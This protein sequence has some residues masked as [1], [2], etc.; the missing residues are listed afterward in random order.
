[1]KDKVIPLTTLKLNEG[2]HGLPKNPR[3]IRDDKF[4]KLC[5]SLKADGEEW[6]R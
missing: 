4:K 3:F 1:M 6:K 2:A 5:D